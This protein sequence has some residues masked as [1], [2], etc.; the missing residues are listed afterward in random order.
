[1]H[2]NNLEVSDRPLGSC[3]L[4]TDSEVKPS[5]EHHRVSFLTDNINV[6]GVESRGC[7]VGQHTALGTL[8]EWLQDLEIF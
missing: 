2:G 4:A 3:H 6:V 1:L 7:D 8:L 5:V